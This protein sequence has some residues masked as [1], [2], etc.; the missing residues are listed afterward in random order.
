MMI[1]D[2]FEVRS[3]SICSTPADLKL[4][5]LFLTVHTADIPAARADPRSDVVLRRVQ[6][7]VLQRSRWVT[8]SM[9]H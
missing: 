9:L 3:V 1:M 2:H 5:L 6:G 7:S 4:V 8:T